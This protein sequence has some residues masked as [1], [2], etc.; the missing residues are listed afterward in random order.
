MSA[1][2][3]S[4]LA[5]PEQRI[6]DLERQLAECKAERD[7]A[8]RQQ[9]AM[10][11]VL[12][13][14]NSSPGDLAPVFEAILEKAHALCGVD[15]GSLMLRDGDRFRAVATYA[16]SET[17]AQRLREGLPLLDPVTGALLDGAHF[18]EVGAAWLAGTARA[19]RSSLRN[20]AIAASNLR[21]CPPR[22]TPRSFRSPAVSSGNTA[23]SIALSRNASS[24]C[25]MPRLARRRC[26]HSP[27]RRDSPPRPFTLPGLQVT[28]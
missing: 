5:N 8:L 7:E 2:P 14:I 22:F 20:A 11:E 17:W 10:G 21:R 28:R 16:Y 6:A 4:T 19:G 12:K 27:P 25:S 18:V 1:T 9:T 13:V 26:P 15:H 3:D 24:Y 23:A